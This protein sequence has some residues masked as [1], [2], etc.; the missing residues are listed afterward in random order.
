MTTEKKSSSD[1]LDSPKF[2]QWRSVKIVAT[3]GICIA[4][5]F[6]SLPFAAK[7]YL[8]KWLLENGA[9][10]AIVEK[11]RVNLF[12]GVAA[13]EGVNVTK[14]NTTVF[15]DATIY[16]NVGLKNLLGHEALLQEVTLAGIL[17]DIE[18]TEDGSLRIGSYTIA[19]EQ[20]GT[21]SER[22]DIAEQVKADN[23][24]ILRASTI[25][26]QDVTVRYREPGLTVELLIEEALIERINT[27]P[28]D[29]DG[30]LTLKGTVNGAPINL[31]L[32]ALVVAPQIDV[33]GNVSL[34]DFPLADLADFLGE[35]LKPFN[36]TA[37]LDGKVSFT[38]T[39]NSDLQVAYDGMIHLDQGDIGGED[40]ATKGTIN[41]NGKA[42]FSMNQEEM[43]VDVD[44]NLQALQA[45]FDMPDPLIDIDNADINIKG[46]T[47]VT[48]AEEVVVESSASLQL[49]PTTFGM[50]IL[51]TSTGETT[52]DGKVRVETGTE[53]KGLNVH[54]D[55]TLNVATPA[56]SMDVGGSLMEVSNQ[57]LVWDGRVEYIMGSGADS[58]S[59][60]R[61]DGTM[62]GETTRFSLPEVIQIQQKKL[63]F[64]GGTEVT[65]AA[66][67]GV[68][69]Q[70]DVIL[71][72]T[73]V[74]MEGIVI[75]DKQMSW[76]G[77]GAYKLEADSQNIS[78]DG[79]FKGEEIYTDVAEMHISQKSLTTEA[80]CTLTLAESPGFK[81]TL[82]VNGKK[83]EIQKGATALL[84]LAEFAMANGRDNGSGGIIIESLQLQHLEMPSSTDLPVAVT[85]PKVT[86]A[87][88]QS[89]DLLSAAIKSLTIEQPLVTDAAGKQQLAALQAI[90]A[91]SITITK[92]LAVTVANVH[93]ENGEFLKEGSQDALATLSTLQVDQIS[94]SLE[95]GFACNTIGL[96]GVYGTFLRKKSPNSEEKQQE[97]ETNTAAEAAAADT[98]KTEKTASGIPVAIQQ[99]TVTGKSGF[100]FTDESLA[101]PFK[102]I[103]AIKSLQVNDIDLNTPEHPFSYSLKG[104]FNKYAPLD[105]EGKC[106]PLAA[107][108]MLEQKASLQNLSM[109]NISSYSV[110]AIGKFFPNGS[111]NIN[112]QLQLGDGRIDMDNNLVFNDLV[113]ETVD[114]ELASELHSQLP[115]PLDLALTML[116]KRDGSIDLDIPIQGELSGLH[117][118]VTDLI[119][120]ALNKG[121]TVAVTPYL[122]YTVLGPLGALAYVGAEVGLSMLDTDLPVLE[123]EHG[124][125][126]LSAEQKEILNRVGKEIEEDTEDSYNICTKVTRDE[127]STRSN[128]QQDNQ[129]ILQDETMRKELFE[130]G[131][132]RSLLVKNYLLSNFAID[133]ERLLICNPGL[134]FAKGSKPK[135]VFKKSAKK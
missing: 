111:L 131:E 58:S 102:T 82:S 31:D 3:I 118:G 109:L 83:T 46:K 88:I 68:S 100:T 74:E 16:L 51:Q 29:T 110:D 49:A 72:E 54:A 56:Y 63:H 33:Q 112:S 15:S 53:T 92:D 6:L 104:A 18:R 130:I 65:I 115:I 13:L 27:D 91:D 12:T 86:V 40:W 90:T 47:L 128:E 24:W 73:T 11:V 8:Q 80:A 77:K 132:N 20:A 96:D 42:S 85:V 95:E 134:E 101:T 38:M 25:D 121:I 87:D 26:I 124:A 34:A 41:Y 61:S 127:L 135:V 59:V 64:S 17:V 114:G 125:A 9:D 81:G 23:P 122:A 94:Y 4:V 28:N 5:V 1:Q 21:D 107:D 79:S 32:N 105:A 99:V 43:T 7:T 45:A 108:F 35:Y 10:S 66:D 120:T 75:G 93:A 14:N 55:G 78:L 129:A 70:G 117:V 133:E 39:E 98:S 84:S 48:I 44:G 52:W 89:P 67:L 57:M 126:E 119:V 76:S 22:K 62:K 19:A 37:G 69:Y 30:N 103:F 123:F 71:G 2:W 36:G 60:V 97:P 116:R 113:V 50:D 106:A